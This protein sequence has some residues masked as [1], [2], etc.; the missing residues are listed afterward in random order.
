MKEEKYLFSLQNR[1]IKLG[2]DRT[3]K[4]LLECGSPHKN[5]KTIQILGT[6]GKGSTSAI[7]ANILKHNN[8]K[9]GLYTSPHLFSFT[10][11]I[12]IN[13]QPIDS[14]SVKHFL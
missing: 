12:R 11:R 14:N 1:G 13:G 5:I 3:K 9:I 6:N 10:E 2:L 7:L 4:L 8:Y